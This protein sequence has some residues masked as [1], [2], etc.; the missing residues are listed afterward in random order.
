[1]IKK[2]IAIVAL[3]VVGF[4]PI[5][6]ALAIDEEMNVDSTFHPVP[7][8]QLFSTS[9]TM[10]DD[11]EVSH[12][13][14]LPKFSFKRLPELN[15]FDERVSRLT[16]GIQQSIAPE[17]DHYGY[18][19]RR[20]MTHDGNLQVFEDRDYLETQIKNVRKAT[21]IVDYWKKYLEKELR[22]VEDIID[23]GDGVSFSNRTAFKQ[24]KVIIRT[25]LISLRGWVAANERFLTQVYEN[26]DAFDVYYPEVMISNNAIRVDFYNKLMLRQTKVNEMKAYRPFEIMVY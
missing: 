7:L 10:D 6:A 24:N 5:Q 23:T 15:S 21:V 19:I 13:P 9:V 17:Y 16:Q 26:M 11:D 18:E 14:N 20:Y 1:M 8:P 3:C 22:E 4:V 25:F 2:V 12:E